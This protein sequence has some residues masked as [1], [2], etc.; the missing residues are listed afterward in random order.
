MGVLNTERV[1]ERWVRVGID[2]FLQWKY[3]FFDYRDMIF[4]DFLQC[5]S[6]HKFEHYAFDCLK[7][8]SYKQGSGGTSL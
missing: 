8:I 7:G 5:S 4:Q 3:I 1:H 6:W 2:V